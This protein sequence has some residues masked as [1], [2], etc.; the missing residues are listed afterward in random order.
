MVRID[1]AGA[2]W[3]IVREPL[4]EH[5]AREGGMPYG[6][7]LPGGILERSQFHKFWASTIGSSLSS[8]LSAGWHFLDFL[9]KSV[10]D[11]NIVCKIYPVSYR[12]GK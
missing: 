10:F 9:K 12:T 7:F 6:A 11:I 3:D 1:S 2:C 5:W 4:P 8:L